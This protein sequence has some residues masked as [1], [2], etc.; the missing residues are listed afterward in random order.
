M[1][2]GGLEEKQLGIQTEIEKAD[3]PRKKA[4]LEV[5]SHMYGRYTHIL[6]LSPSLSRCVCVR[7]RVCVCVNSDF[8]VIH[9]RHCHS[10]SAV[11]EN[12][13]SLIPHTPK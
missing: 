9:P 1:V 6:F 10:Q 8:V 2:V 4:K 3:D 11:K 12:R 13:P 5:R 7:E